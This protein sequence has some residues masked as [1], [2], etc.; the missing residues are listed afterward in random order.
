MEAARGEL[1]VLHL[2]FGSHGP[3]RLSVQRDVHAARIAEP[4]HQSSSG[5]HYPRLL[6]LQC[7]GKKKL[8]IR[9]RQHPHWLVGREFHSNGCVGVRRHGLSRLL[10]GWIR[11]SL[12]RLLIGWILIPLRCA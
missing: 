12:H 4:Q 5:L 1:N 6:G 2:S 3:D 8:S 10:L 11:R 7:A 9:S